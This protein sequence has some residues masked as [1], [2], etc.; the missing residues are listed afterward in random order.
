MLFFQVELVN[1]FAWTDFCDDLIDKAHEIIADSVANEI[2]ERFLSAIFEKDLCIISSM[3]G[4]LA[5]QTGVV[6]EKG[7]EAR[8]G[9]GLALKLALLGQIWLHIKSDGFAQ[10]FSQWLLGKLSFSRVRPDQIITQSERV[11]FQ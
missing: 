5:E 11:T 3:N 7:S 8:D 6:Q 4:A 1:F 2:R 10:E 9:H